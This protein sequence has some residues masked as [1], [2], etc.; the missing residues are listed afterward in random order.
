[1]PKNRKEKE[2]GS[3]VQY[4]SKCSATNFVKMIC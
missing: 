4:H 3:G 2:A 1:M